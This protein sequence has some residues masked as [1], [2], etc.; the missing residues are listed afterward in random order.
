MTRVFQA[1]CQGTELLYGCLLDSDELVAPFSSSS[2]AII[3]LPV[4]PGLGLVWIN[5]RKQIPPV[6][7]N[8]IDDGY[9]LFC[10]F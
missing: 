9:G 6:E 5:C 2:A 4:W 3:I 8:I 1:H 10:S 7:I